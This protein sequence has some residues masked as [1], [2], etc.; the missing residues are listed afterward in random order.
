MKFRNRSLLIFET[1]NEP[2]LRLFSKEPALYWKAPAENPVI[3]P[4]VWTNFH[5]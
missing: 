5:E 4:V 1:K 3:P 2:P